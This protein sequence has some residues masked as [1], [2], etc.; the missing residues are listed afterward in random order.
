MR[1]LGFTT[2]KSRH[3]MC[4][5]NPRR[6]LFIASVVLITIGFLGLIGVLGSIS[7]ASFFNPPYWISWVHLC[8]GMIVLN[9]A[10][11]G[12]RLFQA[13]FVMFPM[14]IGI[15]IGVLGLVFGRYLADRYGL[16]ELADPSDHMAHLIVGMLAAWAWMSRAKAS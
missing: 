6:F 11:K 12:N 2:M 7:P 8:L 1:S 4:D 9:V 3:M 5:M 10:L 14:I 16:P 13:K 15:T